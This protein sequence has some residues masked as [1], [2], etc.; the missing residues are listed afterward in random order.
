MNFCLVLSPHKIHYC[1]VNEFLLIT[2]VNW[3]KVIA[4]QKLQYTSTVYN[5]IITSVPH[6]VLYSIYSLYGYLL[7]R[8]SEVCPPTRWL[9]NIRYCMPSLGSHLLVL[10]EVRGTIGTYGII[11]G[12]IVIPSCLL[13]LRQPLRRWGPWIIT[14]ACQGNPEQERVEQWRWSM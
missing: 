7:T 1:T 6:T 4:W 3:R 9:L 8:S 12:G 5:T 10:L 2:T 11:P 14:I 13:L